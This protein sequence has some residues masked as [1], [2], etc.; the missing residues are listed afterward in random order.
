M[1][2]CVA[3]VALSALSALAFTTF[4]VALELGLCDRLPDERARRA[5]GFVLV[6]LLS[7]GLVQ[8]VFL[9]LVTARALLRL[10]EGSRSSTTASKLDLL[11]DPLHDLPSSPRNR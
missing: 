7:Q 1:I 3:L 11:S 9:L 5:R 6:E 10:L 4:A 8:V 2:F